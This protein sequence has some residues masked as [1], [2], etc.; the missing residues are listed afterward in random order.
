M[1]KKTKTHSSKTI[2][3][4]NVIDMVGKLEKK[5]E[6][7][8]AGFVKEI[9]KLKKAQEQLNKKVSQTPQKTTKT[10]QTTKTKSTPSKNKGKGKTTPKLTVVR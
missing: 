4:V 8:M 5:I 7:Q 10:N 1:V 9:V 3:N 2:E 6:K